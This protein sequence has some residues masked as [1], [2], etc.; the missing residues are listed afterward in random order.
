[1][2]NG[3][4]FTIVEYM[5]DDDVLAFKDLYLT[6]ALENINQFQKALVVLSQNPKNVEALE[7][8]HRSIHT[9]KSKSLMM[10]YEITGTI[11]KSIEDILYEA[12]NNTKPLTPELVQLLIT[13][14]TKLHQ[15]I[16]AI[17]QTDKEIDLSEDL[18]TLTGGVA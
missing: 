8:A 16:D 10:G 12:K 7:L 18:T 11:S 3:V 17:K 6:T 4:V 14:G 2:I 5:G 15:S 13:I 1:M 9:L